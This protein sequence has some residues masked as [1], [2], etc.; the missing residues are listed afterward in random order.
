MERST[1]QKVLLVFSILEIIGAALTL[2]GAMALIAATGVIGMSGSELSSDELAA[3]ISLG[4]IGS[5]LLII[6]GVWS[7][8]CGIFGIRAANDN[9][10]IMVVWV[11]VIIGLVLCIISIISSIINGDFAS[12]AL[13]LLISLALNIIMFV[14]AN[15]IKREAGK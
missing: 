6:S 2:F 3:G 8:L 11:F 7:L 4:A 15:N 12:N 9:Q 13:S 5:I 14:V 10:K 1:S